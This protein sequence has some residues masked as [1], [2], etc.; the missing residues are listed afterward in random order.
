MRALS[1]QLIEFL[2]AHRVGVLATADGVAMPRQSVVYYV[3]EEERLLI[4][5]ESKRLKAR[6]VRRS[7]W[8]SLC[9]LGH[10]RPYPSAVFSG[11]AEILTENIGP[12]TAAIMQRIAGM[13]ESPPPESDAAL[14]AI[15]R[16][17][18]AITIEAVSAVNYL[19]PADAW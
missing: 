6:D 19:D 18:L 1:P 16:V 4:S 10:E 14:A 5:T 17:I 12:A 13:P 15:D 8:A 9:V 2:D 3:R 11:R 7:G